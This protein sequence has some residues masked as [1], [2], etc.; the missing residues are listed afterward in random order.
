MFFYWW[1]W[2]FQQ[3]LVRKMKSSLNRYG[4]LLFWTTLRENIA[5]RLTITLSQ[6]RDNQTYFIFSLTTGFW[7]INSSVRLQ[8]LATH[9]L[10]F[11]SGSIQSNTFRNLRVLW[12]SESSHTRSVDNL[13]V[14]SFASV[15]RI[16]LETNHK[17]NF[18]HSIAF[19][20]T[21]KSVP[22]KVSLCKKFLTH[23]RWIDRSRQS[24][25]VDRLTRR[26]SD[27]DARLSFFCG[28]LN[29]LFPYSLCAENAW[30]ELIPIDFPIGLSIGLRSDCIRNRLKNAFSSPTELVPLSVPLSIALFPPTFQSETGR[31]PE[32]EKRVFHGRHFRVTHA[33]KPPWFS[34]EKTRFFNRFPI[35]WKTRF[36]IEK[37]N[38]TLFGYKN[39]LYKRSNDLTAGF[40]EKRV[41]CTFHHMSLFTH[42]TRI[43]KNTF[44]QLKTDWKSD[45][46]RIDVFD[47][48]TG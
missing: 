47:W 13:S 46:I 28:T 17:I 30:A 18:L 1:N 45:P 44:F 33:Q 27:D 3:I 8:R 21:Q 19:I 29:R 43:E 9:S 42:T 2:F 4:I 31:K 32:T 11:R 20:V 38:F 26:R 14:V 35:D 5:V 36:S 12:V 34:I 24:T 16:R 10:V 6:Q 25:S 37:Q 23:Q 15:E 40:I 48:K 22:M 7:L 39:I 41:L